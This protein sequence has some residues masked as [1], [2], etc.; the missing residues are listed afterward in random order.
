MQALVNVHVR[1]LIIRTLCAELRQSDECRHLT[2]PGRTRVIY[3]ESNH[4]SVSVRQAKIIP[5]SFHSNI[6]AAYV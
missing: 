6:S 3:S 5:I 4:P 1:N 2:V